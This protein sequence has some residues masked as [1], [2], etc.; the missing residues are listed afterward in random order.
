MKHL[1]RDTIQEVDVSDLVDLSME[2]YQTLLRHTSTM[3]QPTTPSTASEE[4]PAL[5]VINTIG[6][7]DSHLHYQGTT[8]RCKGQMH[9][10]ILIL[11]EITVILIFITVASVI[12]LIPLEMSIILVVVK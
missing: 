3:L 10:F 1:S 7:T 6:T 9:V 2:K 4:D 5:E 12:L 11:I 8:S